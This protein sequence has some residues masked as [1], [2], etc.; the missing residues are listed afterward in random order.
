VT[1]DQ[2]VPRTAPAQSTD[3]TRVGNTV[4]DNGATLIA[5]QASIHTCT[6]CNAAIITNGDPAW[7]IPCGRR[8]RKVAPRAT[9]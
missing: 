4:Q 8:I 5:N 1:W 2:W 7:C 3:P 9:H 6:R